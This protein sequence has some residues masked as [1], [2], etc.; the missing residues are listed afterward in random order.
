MSLRNTWPLALGAGI[1][2]L[3]ACGFEDDSGKKASPFPMGT[4][5]TGTA[6]TPASS[7]GTFGTTGGDTSAAG[8]F[9][10][11]S[12]TGFGQAGDT[13]FGGSG[14][15]GTGTAGSDTAGTASGGTAPAVVC[16]TPPADPVPL[17]M[18]VATS[19]AP[20][21]YFAGP[22]GNV[23][24]IVQGTCEER[25]AENTIGTCYKFSFKATTVADG[26][27]AGVF[28]QYGNQN[29]GSCPGLPVAAGATKV[30]FKAWGAVGGEVVEF[31]AG[32]IGDAGTMYKDGVQLGQGGG[33]KLT[34]T[35]TPTAY[36]VDLKG[37]TY[38]D[39]VLG[40]Y[41]WSLA[42]ATVDENPTFYVDEIEWVQ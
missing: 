15:G 42:V 22:D 36:T 34:L 23:G 26:A 3:A 29:W 12:G 8:T 21:G 6:G 9:G 39:G 25:P 16:T 7:A 41:V 37:Q 5:G 38:P 40:G 4:S 10:N 2:L 18:V 17:P 13:S 31:S 19:F 28:W 32:G 35:T 1:T 27:Y 14:S 30:S 33:N 11:V 20:S 24:G